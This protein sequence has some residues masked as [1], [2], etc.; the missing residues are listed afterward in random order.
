MTAQPSVR[1]R[2]H[3]NMPDMEQPTEA[4]ISVD[5]EAAGPSPSTGSLLSIGACLI[6]DPEVGYYVELRPIAER[7]WDDEAEAIHGLSRDRL[8]RDGLEPT[9]AMQQFA[10]WVETITAG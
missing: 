8:V 10:A 4:L 1:T 5:I 3:G 6:E 2:A 7:D 9:D